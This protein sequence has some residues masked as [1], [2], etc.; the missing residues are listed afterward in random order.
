MVPT[1]NPSSS[2]RVARA[3]VSAKATTDTRSR[4]ESLAPVVE[5]LT[6]IGE[7]SHWIVSN[8]LKLEPRDRSRGKY[9]IK[10]KNRIK[11]QFQAFTEREPSRA[12][13]QTVERDLARM[14]EYLEHPSNLP[15]GRGIAIFACEPL[16]LFEAIPLAR[17]FRSRLAIDHS[18]LV[19]ELAALND[20]YGRVLC[21]VY[22]RTAARFFDVSAK[23]A[24]E[25][26][27]LSAGDTTRAGRFHA[28]SESRTH[29]NRGDSH[30]RGVGG[31]ALGEHNFNQRIR[32][33][34]HRHYQ[35]IAQRL[36]AL[37]RDGGVVGVVLAGT[38]ADVS[39]VSSH[40]HPYVRDAVLGTTKLNPKSATP[41][42][43]MEAVLSV[44][45]DTERTWES[46]HVDELGESLGTNWAVNG[47]SNTL[48]ALA[49]GQVRTLLVNP[50]AA[51]PGYRCSASGRLV[52]EQHACDGEGPPDPVVD[53]IDE[54][55]EEALR[56]GCHVDVVEDTGLWDRVDGLA[57]LLRFKLS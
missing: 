54:A 39:A 25:L 32:E 57:G 43:V 17:V 20:E 34:K 10:L 42:D 19:R 11:E 16:D 28:S 1:A 47:V 31:S 56:Q 5:R 24:V 33:E 37:S 8:Y 55:I 30:G 2:K 48:A 53:V 52:N 51:Q 9:L 46:R 40:L 38:G 41:T 49:R 13:R 23:E 6:A 35:Q 44:R 27:G 7:S 15:T 29:G 21:V 14:R 22:D 12:A 50:S 45:R 4:A 18:P 3:N 26:T 36:F